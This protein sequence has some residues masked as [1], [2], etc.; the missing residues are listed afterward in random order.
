MRLFLA[1][2]TAVLICGAALAQEF[3]LTITHK[4]GTTTIEEVPKRVASVDYNGADNLLALGIQPVAV[5]YWYGDFPDA[6][7]PWAA[8]RLT[9]SPEILRGDLNFEQVAASE[10]DVIIAL[11]SGIT[12]YEY[13][14]LSKI[15][16][17]IAVPEG[18]GDY[19]LTWDQLALIAGESTGRRDIA[20][21]LVADL[22]NRMADMAARNPDWQGK[23]AVVAYHWRRSPGVYAGD[24]IRPLI[25]SNLGFRTPEAVNEIMDDGEFAITISEEELPIIDADL[26][27]WVTDG[28]QGQRNRIERM[29]L[30]P[31]L[32]AYA[33]G[34]EVFTDGILTGAFSHGSLLS[35]PYVLD[36]LEPKIAAAVDGDPTTIVPE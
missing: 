17:V 36:A 30:R 22:Q 28:S 18:V 35:L 20:E 6:V 23:T 26:L 5:R 3:P 29:A 11:W 10:P 9:S 31:S 7:W 12:A 33:E 2:I 13:D 25:L 27:I 19:A 21:A 16:P 1:A 4:F 14:Q 32:S 24:D 15:A 8:D 34:R